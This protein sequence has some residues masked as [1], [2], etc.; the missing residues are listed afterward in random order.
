[1]ISITSF[2]SNPLYQLPN[3][4]VLEGIMVLRKKNNKIA[5]KSSYITLHPQSGSRDRGILAL[6]LP[7][8]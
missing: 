6:A 2:P 5:K 8:V 1:M 3:I 4:G 7:S